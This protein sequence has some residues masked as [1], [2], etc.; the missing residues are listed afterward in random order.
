[1]AENVHM[2]VKQKE[3]PAGQHG[4]QLEKRAQLTL[5]G[6]DDIVRFSEDEVILKTDLGELHII[7]QGMQILK[8]SLEENLV[9]MDGRVSALIYQETAQKLNA[10]QLL[11]RALR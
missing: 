5:T 10:R 7:G 9:K 1:M 8:L 3:L 11:R 2:G 6:V 4:L